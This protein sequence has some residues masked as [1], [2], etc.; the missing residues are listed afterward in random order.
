MPLLVHSHRILAEIQ[1]AGQPLGASFA[2]KMDQF[3]QV[4]GVVDIHREPG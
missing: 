1:T 3:L 2:G 4:G